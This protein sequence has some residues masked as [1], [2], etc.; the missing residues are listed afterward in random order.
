MDSILAFLRETTTEIA[1]FREFAESIKAL[2][3]DRPQLPSDWI[4]YVWNKRF[5]WSPEYSRV[6][7]KAYHP[8]VIGWYYVAN[9]NIAPIIEVDCGDLS[10]RRAG[11]IYWSKD[12]AAPHGLS[13]DISSFTEWY[14]R[15]IRWIRKNGQRLASERLGP[16]YMPLAW[17]E[18][19]ELKGLK[20][21]GG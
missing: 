11:R 9:K 7:E 13:Y 16:Y 4:F 18:I 1:V 5:T 21:T 8:E 12:F 17:N 3:I 19:N 15:I 10:R 6:S 2:W 14:D 20:T